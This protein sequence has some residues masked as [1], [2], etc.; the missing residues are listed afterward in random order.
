MGFLILLKFNPSQQAAELNPVRIKNFTVI[1]EQD[2]DGYYVVS[3]PALK[4]C[5]TRGKTIDETIHNIK[6]AIE[7]CLEY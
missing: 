6:E 5:H 3:A 2:E 4:G 1:I 7:L